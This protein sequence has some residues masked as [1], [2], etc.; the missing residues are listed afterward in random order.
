MSHT[1][2][3][4]TTLLMTCA[5]FVTVAVAAPVPS[6]QPIASSGEL[7]RTTLQPDLTLK[8]ELS[9]GFFP[10]PAAERLRLGFCQ[11]GCGIRCET[12]ADCGGAAC[13]PFI[14]CCVRGEPNQQQSTGKSTRIGEV[15]V[16]NVKCK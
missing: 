7:I 6:D 3:V 11:C 8:G 14:T 4:L 16:S 13:R 9:P 12:S 15:A 5:L 10:T 1:K 2:V